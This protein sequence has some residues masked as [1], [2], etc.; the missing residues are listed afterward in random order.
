MND[1]HRTA[2][3]TD[4]FKL[5]LRS[6]GPLPPDAAADLLAVIQAGLR[7]VTKSEKGKSRPAEFPDEVVEQVLNEIHAI[8]AGNAE[9]EAKLQQRLMSADQRNEE[10]LRTAEEV[11]EA[12]EDCFANGLRLRAKAEPI[13][14]D[15]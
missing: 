3:A 11:K 9:R 1:Q 7:K 13:E 5:V 15:E 14:S 8:A 6:D 12:V 10:V 4:R 2:P